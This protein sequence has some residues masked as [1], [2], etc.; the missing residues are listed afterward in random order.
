MK[1]NILFS[2]F[3]IAIIF[4]S[5]LVWSKNSHTDNLLLENVEALSESEDSGE[6]CGGYTEWSVSGGIFS[7]KKEF[8]DCQ[9]KLRRGYKPQG[10]CM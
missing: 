10:N 2:S 9:C 7:S 4:A 1:R 3:C 8:Y 6:S 5:L